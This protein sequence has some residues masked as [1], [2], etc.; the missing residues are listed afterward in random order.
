M[1]RFSLRLRNKAL[2]DVSRIRIWYRKIDP[3]L[4]DRFV[5]ALN[6]GLDRIEAH[7]FGYQV[8]YR[9]S[10]RLILDKFPYSIYYMIQ[11]AIIIVLAVIHHR[12]NRE[13]ARVIAE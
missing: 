11:D 2:D 12:R 7:P 13:L 9:N 1:G 6:V 5:R 3:V 4:E 8:V 10:R